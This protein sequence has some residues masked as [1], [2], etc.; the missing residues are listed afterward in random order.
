MTDISTT[1][2]E[3]ERTFLARELPKGLSTRAA[4]R[5]IDIY[6]PA[7][8]PHPHLRLRQKGD[9]Y[10][11]TKKE[12]IDGKDSSRQTEQTIPLTAAEFDALRQVAGKVVVKDRYQMTIDGYA[13]EVD[14]FQEDL[15]GLVL[16]DFEFANELAMEEFIPPECCLA[17]V[18][19]EAFIAGGILAGKCYADLEA[20]LDEYGYRPFSVK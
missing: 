11:I 3:L 1:T 2:I 10:E 4:E 14:V 8:A 5:M 9:R 12:P 15:V 20:K 19:Q 13:A 16:L 17:D 7:S 18:T 6:V